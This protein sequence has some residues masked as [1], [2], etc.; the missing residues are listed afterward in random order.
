MAWL[1]VRGAWV[2]P[3][4]RV[5]RR[6][7]PGGRRSPERSCRS[8]PEAARLETPSR[9]RSASRVIGWPCW[10]W[11]SAARRAAASRVSSSSSCSGGRPS[12]ATGQVTGAAVLAG[13]AGGHSSTGT[14]KAWQ[15]ARTGLLAMRRAIHAGCGTHPVPVPARWSLPCPLTAAGRDSGAATAGLAGDRADC[16]ARYTGSARTCRRSTPS[17]NTGT[18]TGTCR[19]RSPLSVADLQDTAKVNLPVDSQTD[20]SAKLLKQSSVAGRRCVTYVNSWP[21]V[22]GLVSRSPTRTHPLV[23]ARRPVSAR[24]REVVR[25]GEGRLARRLAGG[26]GSNQF[27][28]G[29]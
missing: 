27:S 4:S 14:G 25:P 18:N 5:G 19:Q 23:R 1:R 9:A 11:C 13:D 28:G 16:A 12:P 3:A 24:P 8:R 26:E 20:I 22:G 2:P 10:S 15:C 7:A 17:A 29:A 21:P 6:E